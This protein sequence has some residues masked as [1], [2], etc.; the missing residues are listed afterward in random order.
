MLQPLMEHP[1]QRF[2]QSL[3]LVDVDET[4]LRATIPSQIKCLGVDLLPLSLGHYVHLRALHNAFIVGELPGM[5]DL[6]LGAF[7]CSQPFEDGL[8][9][10]RSP[11]LKWFFKFRGWRVRK[12]NLAEQMM[13]FRMYLQEGLGVADKNYIEGQSKGRPLASPWENRL[14]LILMEKLGLSESEVMNRPLSRSQLDYDTISEMEGG[15]EFFS[16]RDAAMFAAARSM[17]LEASK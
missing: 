12:C 10:M 6:I 17:P 8:K 13:V 4:F 14:K 2:P 1:T 5:E 3:N 9:S 7:I 11:W 15:T 16:S